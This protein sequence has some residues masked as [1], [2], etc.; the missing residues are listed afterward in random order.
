MKSG[1]SIC[2]TNCSA[3]GLSTAAQSPQSEIKHEAEVSSVSLA[4]LKP[5]VANSVNCLISA[6]ASVPNSPRRGVIA[7]MKL[8]H[9]RRRAMYYSQA[10]TCCGAS[11]RL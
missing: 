11:I 8:V 2:Y 9:C 5:F 6:A 3:K 10:E 4:S 1:T 7:Q